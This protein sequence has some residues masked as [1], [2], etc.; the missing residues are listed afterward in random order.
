MQ[1]DIQQLVPEAIVPAYATLG[2]GC[3]DIY[4]IG[5]GQDGLIV[6]QEA[7]QIVGTGLAFE[8]PVGWVMKVYSRSGH[9]F[10]SDVRLGNC[11]GII[12]SDYRGELMIKLAA[13]G[14]PFVVQ[15]GKAIAQAMLVLA[16]RVTFNVVAKLSETERGAG[17]FGSSDKK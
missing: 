10:K 15:S 7:P 4:P 13:D 9:G 11:V 14:E 5:I 1:F 17:G 16:P 3:F 12:D 8:V 2:A 6:R